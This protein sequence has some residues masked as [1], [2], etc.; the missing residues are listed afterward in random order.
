M[1]VRLAPIFL[2]IV[3][4]LFWEWAVG[5]FEV[6]PFLLPPPSSIA[7]AIWTDFS[8]LW[9][10]LMFTLRITWTA[11]AF[12][13]LSGLALGMLFS[14]SRMAEG[15]LFP[16]AVVLQVTPVVAIAPAIIVWVGLDNTERALL[17]IAWIVA[18]FPVLSNTTLGFK[19]VD[20]NLKD[21]FSIYR[22]SHWQRLIRLE[23][24][25]ALPFILAGIKIS[26]GLALIGAVVAEFVAGSGDAA[27]LA[28]RINEASNRLNMPRMF[29]ALILL[30]GVGIL[31]FYALTLIE[32]LALKRWHESVA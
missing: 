20:R 15:L 22:A 9:N 8:L 32:R 18:F 3:L 17:I 30:A 13:I 10:S 21:L 7:Q 5:A 11:L 12:A 31:Q 2:G 23:L 26:A 29:A 28:W 25:A 24:P 4:I 16:Y 27:G 6:S 14:Q 1:I 19:S